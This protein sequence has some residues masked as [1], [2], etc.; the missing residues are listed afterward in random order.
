MIGFFSVSISLAE[1]VGSN[2]AFPPSRRISSL[3]RSVTCVLP[4]QR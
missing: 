2:F 3:L 4:S 1:S